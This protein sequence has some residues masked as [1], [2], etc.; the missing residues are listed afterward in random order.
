MEQA[1][2]RAG[3]RTPRK[4]SRDAG[5]EQCQVAG[6]HRAWR[7]RKCALHGGQDNRSDGKNVE[8]P[9]M[10]G[11]EEHQ[12]RRV[13]EDGWCCRPVGRQREGGCSSDTRKSLAP[14]RGSHLRRAGYRESILQTLGY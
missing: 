10:E 14:P 7:A 13:R 8:T 11:E 1:F 6:K 12:A 4:Q 5:V 9:G 2:I 3:L